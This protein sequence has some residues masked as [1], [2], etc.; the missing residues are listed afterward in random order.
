[1][2]EKI[3]GEYYINTSYALKWL[4]DK[5]EMEQAISDAYRNSYA[6]TLM[7]ERNGS[8]DEFQ[9]FKDGC[10]V[11][12]AIANVYLDIYDMIQKEMLKCTSTECD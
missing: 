3:N 4:H 9:L 10:F 8:A 5:C 2:V 7:G 11:A 12:N 6:R 1:M